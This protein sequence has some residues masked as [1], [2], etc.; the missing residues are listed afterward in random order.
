MTF[1]ASRCAALMV[2]SLLLVACQSAQPQPAPSPTDSEVVA[3]PSIQEQFDASLANHQLA[4]AEQQLAA[5]GQADT[6]AAQLQRTQRRLAEAYL[7]EGQRSL[8]AGDLDQAVKSLSRARSLMPEAPALTTGLDGAIGKA[9]EVELTATE[10]AR[11]ADQQAQAARQER[12]RLL[13]Q[14]AEA[15]AAATRLDESQVPP[16]QTEPD[17]VAA[18]GSMVSL[19]M[20]DSRDEAALLECLAAAAAEIVTADHAVHLQVRSLQDLT[21]VSSLLEEQVAK[22]DPSYRLRLSTAVRPVQV[23]R[24]LLQ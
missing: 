21:R 16:A 3:K 7:R 20:L 14:A 2:L 24:L 10:Q 18:G 1:L 13:R 22:H 6:D 12:L 15:Q 9:Q 17:G 23:P 4:E 5:M 8:Q 19:A 11:Q